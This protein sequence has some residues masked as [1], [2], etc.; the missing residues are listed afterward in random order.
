VTE[1]IQRIKAELGVNITLG[2]S[3]FSF[4]LPARSLLSNAFLA[5]AIAAGVNCPIVDVAKVRSIVLATDL[6]LNRDKRARRYI[7]AF[8]QRL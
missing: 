3:N 2:A 1:T 8:R 5:I 4:G 7:D 6:A